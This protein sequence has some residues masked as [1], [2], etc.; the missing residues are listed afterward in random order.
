M[1]NI[2]AETAFGRLFSFGWFIAPVLIA[3][4]IYG[5][6][7]STL[8]PKL[9]DD[10]KQMQAEAISDAQIQASAY[11]DYYEASGYSTTVS[12][13]NAG[14]NLAI[15]SRSILEKMIQAGFSYDMGAYSTYQAKMNALPKII[16]SSKSLSHRASLTYH[17]KLFSLKKTLGDLKGS[18]Q[19]LSILVAIAIASQ[20]ETKGLGK[21][22]QSTQMQDKIVSRKD[23]ELINALPNDRVVKIV[24]GD[25]TNT[26]TGAVEPHALVEVS[27]TKSTGEKKTAVIDP[28]M[29]LSQPTTADKNR[30]MSYFCFVTQEKYAENLKLLSNQ[31][32]N[33][34]SEIE[35]K[36]NRPIESIY[37]D[38]YDTARIYEETKNY[39]FKPRTM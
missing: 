17:K 6:I 16:K 2:K 20:R 39:K 11:P 10:F 19:E 12:K 7:K 8:P 3:K 13:R 38:L 5:N 22:T 15:Y 14:R 31:E 36:R 30:A 29:I 27:Y 28:A 35:I 24:F 4:F 23:L 37:R 33:P 18:C 21:L 1:S 32:F 26:I 25:I 9:K 34:T